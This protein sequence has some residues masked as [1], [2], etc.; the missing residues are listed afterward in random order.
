M[1][2]EYKRVRCYPTDVNETFDGKFNPKKFRNENDAVE[3]LVV[4]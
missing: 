3:Y 1:K 2:K 4:M